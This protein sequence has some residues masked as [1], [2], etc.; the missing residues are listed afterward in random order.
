MNHPVVLEVIEAADVTALSIE[1]QAIAFFK[2]TA[3]IHGLMEDVVCPVIQGQIGKSDYE[4]AVAVTFYRIALLL[5]GL[6]LLNDPAQFQI[7]NSVARTVFELVLDLNLLISDQ[8]T[9]DKFHGF[10]RVAKFRKA[11]QL[12]T[13]LDANPSVDKA[14][15]QD[16]INFAS[17]TQRQQ[18]VEQAC[19]Q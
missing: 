2:G 7:V 16:A 3:S 1:E 13:F 9:A 11:A 19:I 10:S 15:H 6:R 8:A 18:E 12:K 4:Q 17:D 5:R 14:P